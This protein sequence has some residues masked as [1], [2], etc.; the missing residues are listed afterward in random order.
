LVG[1]KVI[2]SSY[3]GA[4]VETTR[5]EKILGKT[6][7][8]FEDTPGI[9]SISDR[10]EEEKITEKKLFEGATDGAIM[11]VDS[12]SLERSLYI[13]LQILE[14]QIPIIMAL[15]F[16][17]EAEKKGIEIDYKKLEKLLNVPVIPINPLKNKGINELIDI[18]LRDKRTKGD[19]FSVRYDDD[20]EKAIDKVSPKIIQTSLS[21]RF[22]ALRVLEEDADF[23]RYLKDKEVIKET[24]EILS[25]YPKVSEDISIT[26]YGTAAFISISFRIGLYCASNSSYE[27]PIL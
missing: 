12:T 9:Y 14:A 8:I 18:I 10:S 23:Y 2:I 11:V 19:I 26:R 22:I 7:I 1:S 3:P 24:K 13:V 4:S 25:N 15:N 27:N 21:K 5:G 20:I 6:K 16:V 17:E